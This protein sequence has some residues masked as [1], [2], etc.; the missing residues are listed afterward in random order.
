MNDDDFDVEE[1]LIILDVLGE[2]DDWLSS[3][4]V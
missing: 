2:D 4:R 3:D 1:D